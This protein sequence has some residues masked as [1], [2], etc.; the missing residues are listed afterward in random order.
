LGRFLT[1]QTLPSKLI[2]TD[3]PLRLK[4]LAAHHM[5]NVRP[6]FE[7]H[8]MAG[9]TG[10]YRGQ[11]LAAIACGFGEAAA[12]R[13]ASEAYA[14]GTRTFLYIGECTALSPYL[15]LMDVLTAAGGN[16]HLQKKAQTAAKQKNI[17]LPTERVYTNDTYRSDKTAPNGYIA[18]DFATAGFYRAVTSLGG[19]ALSVLTVSENAATGEQ[20]ENCVRQS[21]FHEAALLAFEILAL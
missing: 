9:Y 3:D 13:C 12:M 2:L 7:N 21:R 11:A 14:L 18:V 8:G 15:K 10:T 6:L 1:A 4:M 17:P 5:D 19:E 20:A 16:K